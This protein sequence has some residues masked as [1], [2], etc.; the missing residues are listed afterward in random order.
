[1]FILL[2]KII[3]QEQE[4][5]VNI[6]FFRGRMYIISLLVH[7]KDEVV[8]EQLLNIQ[9]F[10]PSAKVVI[11]VS[12]SATFSFSELDNYLKNKVDNYY[13]NPEQAQTTWG[14]LF[15]LIS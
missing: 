4:P 10:F 9:K 15:Q 14:G 3:N 13:I 8:L 2:E 6:Y 7:E 1:M 5:A 12:K 11:H